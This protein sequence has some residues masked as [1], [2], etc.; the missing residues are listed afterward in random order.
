MAL[1]LVAA[2]YGWSEWGASPDAPD[3]QANQGRDVPSGAPAPAQADLPAGAPTA[4]PSAV[5]GADPQQERPRGRCTMPD[6]SVVETIN[7]V[8]EDIQMVWDDRPYSPIVDKVF[9]NGWWWWKHEDGSYSTVKMIDM[10]G[11]PQAMAMSAKEDP[12]AVK[13]T[14]DEAMKQAA[15]QG[16]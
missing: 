6:G 7:D 5:A 4:K 9:H 11:V 8:Y 13:P 10:N 2:G 15:E 1:L 16:K 14:A 12:S 3:P